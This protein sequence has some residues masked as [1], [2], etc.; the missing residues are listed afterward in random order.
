MLDAVCTVSGS[1]VRSVA[2]VD[3]GIVEIR[4]NEADGVRTQVTRQVS[5]GTFGHPK[6]V[7]AST[8][9]K[10]GGV[11]GDGDS[12]GIVAA[13]AVN[14]RTTHVS[15]EVDGIV[16]GTKVNDVITSAAQDDVIALTMRRRSQ[17]R[18]CQ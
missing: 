2:A 11:D 3:S 13:L 12:Q 9:R 18:Y 6:G 10:R 7:I 1:G 4:T 17:N 8:T 5:A 14:N 15:G 16:A